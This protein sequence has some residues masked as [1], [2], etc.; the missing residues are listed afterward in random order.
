MANYSTRNDG[1]FTTVTVAQDAEV[2]GDLTVAGNIVLGMPGSSIFVSGTGFF[3]AELTVGGTA[4]LQ[5][6]LTV[7][8][9]AS[10]GGNLAV[11]G[12]ES[13]SG[14][15][16]AVGAISTPGTVTSNTVT[17]TS[18]LNL[19]QVNKGSVSPVGQTGAIIYNTPDNLVYFSNGS[20]WVAL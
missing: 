2:L 13:V 6:N 7:G 17:A 8:G 11:G 10:I 4:L 12:S 18:F 19:P 15:L 3:G 16:S 9:F 1:F 5:S 20:A 14:N